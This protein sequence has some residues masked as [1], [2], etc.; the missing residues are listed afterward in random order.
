LDIP[1]GDALTEFGP[2]SAGPHALKV[3][4]PHASNH[5]AVLPIERDDGIHS[6]ADY[7]G[8]NGRPVVVLAWVQADTGNRAW[9]KP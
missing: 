7:K 2:L 9:W 5:L 6:G 8:D 4:E 1:I 3:R